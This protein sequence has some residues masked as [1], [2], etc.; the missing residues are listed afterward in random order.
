[1]K[2]YFIL[3]LSSC[4]FPI[5]MNAQ[6]NISWQNII[7]DGASGNENSGITVYDPNG[8]V[9]TIGIILPSGM[10][11]TDLVIVK[12]DATG[13]ELWRTFCAGPARK[14]EKIMDAVLDQ[15]GDLVLW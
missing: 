9:Y 7:D 8:Y 14:N 3:L 6:L 5:L 10:N 15:N 12:Y 1:M 13:N 2:K 11:N 4:L